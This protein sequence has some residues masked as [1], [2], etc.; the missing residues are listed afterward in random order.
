M[1]GGG[2][3]HYAEGLEKIYC[4]DIKGNH[5]SE[6]PTQPDPNFGFPRARCSYGCAKW[7]QDVYISGGRHYNEEEE[8]R[9]LSDIWHFRIDTFQ[10]RKLRMRLPEPLYFHSAIVSPS[11]H[12]FIFGGVHKDR[13]RTANLYK[14]RLPHTMP[15]LVELCWEKVCVMARASKTMTPSHLRDMGVPWNLSDRLHL[16]S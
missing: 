8:H 15:K 11:G 7:G 12:M 9:S 14:I 2:R 6:V 1:L 13:S 16:S 10:W 3:L 5:W 4:Y